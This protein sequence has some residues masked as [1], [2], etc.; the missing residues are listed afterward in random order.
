MC[1]RARRE[2]FK[3]VFAMT[4]IGDAS[5]KFVVFDGTSKDVLPMRG[6]M[7]TAT[8]CVLR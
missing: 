3:V 1:M 6:V 4:S 2:D 7:E 8:R 5:S